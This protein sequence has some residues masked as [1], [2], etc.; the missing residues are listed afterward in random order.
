MKE[1]KY[2]SAL[3]LIV[4]LTFLQGSSHNR[5]LQMKKLIPQETP[6]TSYLKTLLGDN[7]IL[8]NKGI[9]GELTG[10][11]LNRFR[12]DVIDHKP[13]FVVILGG[14]NDI[15]WGIDNNT[16][17]NNLKAMIQK[18]L[19]AGITPIPCAIP[20]LIGNKRMIEYR[21]EINNE[22]A[23]FAKEKN[24]RFVNLFTATA[25][26]N[27]NLDKK[28]NNDGLHLNTDGYKLFADVIYEQALKS[29]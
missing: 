21:Q 13:D 29:Q 12:R 18:A 6:Y 22:I 8:E 26:K 2:L 20:S 14:T 9:N 24:L 15:G 10:Q 25:D 11:M 27:L 23:E 7:W 28:Y 16:I 19:D 17:I 4:F 1:N 3:Y 5:T